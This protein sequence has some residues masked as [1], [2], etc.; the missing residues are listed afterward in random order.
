MTRTNKQTNKQSNKKW[1]QTE[2]QKLTFNKG[3]RCLYRVHFPLI[4][5]VASMQNGGL[6]LL[7]ELPYTC[8]AHVMYKISLMFIHGFCLLYLIKWEIGCTQHAYFTS[9]CTCCTPPLPLHV[10]LYMLYTP[11]PTWP[12]PAHAVYHTPTSLNGSAFVDVH[13][14]YPVNLF[15]STPFTFGIK[16]NT[17]IRLYIN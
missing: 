4:R 17:T 8:Y 13:T 10:T 1:N 15:S 12:H 2:L 9:S 7:V 14:V 6:Y 16:T 5:H 3:A 11:T